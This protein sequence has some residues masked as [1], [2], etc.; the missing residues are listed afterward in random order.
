MGDEAIIHCGEFNL[1]GPG[2]KAARSAVSK[3]QR[4]HSFELMRESAADRQLVDSLNEISKRWRGDTEERGFTME[5][6]REVE[7]L[8]ED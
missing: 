4:E 8:D 3:V 2:M 6:D 7:G 5:S 1:Q